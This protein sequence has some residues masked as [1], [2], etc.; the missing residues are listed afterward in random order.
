MS[1]LDR[2][3]PWR[4]WNNELRKSEKRLA[5]SIESACQTNER[6][7]QSAEEERRQSDRA[8]RAADDAIRSVRRLQNDKR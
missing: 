3:M 7:R 2:I 8:I 1:L 5:D 6:I 4:R